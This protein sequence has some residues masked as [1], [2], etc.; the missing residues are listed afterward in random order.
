MLNGLVIFYR[1]RDN[2]FNKFVFDK[3]NKKNRMDKIEEG[4]LVTGGNFPD[5]IVV[6]GERSIVFGII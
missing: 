2:V 3:I 5:W 4:S 1:I 6:K